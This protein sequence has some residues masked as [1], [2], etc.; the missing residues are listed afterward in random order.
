MFEMEQFVR[1][2]SNR[3]ISNPK[4]PSIFD[5]K[6]SIRNV[7]KIYSG[8]NGGEVALHAVDLELIGPRFC[9]IVGKSGSGKSTLLNL[10]AG[11]DKPTEGKLFVSDT[12]IHLLDETQGANWRR[13]NLGMIFQ[14]FQLLPALTVLEN[15]LLPM[16]L[17]KRLDG[18]A[19]RE[20]AFQLLEE[21]EL[22][23]QANKLP[24]HLS[25]GQQQRC[26]IAR[27]I[28]N[29]PSIIIADEPTGNLD[30]GTA[31]LVLNLLRQYADDGKLVI[32]VTH[33]KDIATLADQ[34]ITLSDGQ[35][36]SATSKETL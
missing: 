26:A 28:A 18:K 32:V 35:V 24:S 10:I 6:I 13:E 12:P 3:E 25:G 34:V 29:Q 11:L 21:V 15:I 16:S 33:D 23:D 14:N 2:L 36:E 20:R 5:T 7:S 27:A 8:T 4:S 19:Q 22:A 9:A 31:M 17:S 30:T 1:N